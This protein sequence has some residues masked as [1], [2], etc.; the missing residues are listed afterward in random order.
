V[1][2]IG[3][4]VDA[5]IVAS[6]VQQRKLAAHGVPRVELVPM[7]VERDVFRPDAR[8][9]GLRRELL[10]ADAKVLAVG[11]GR[12][13]VEKR[14]PVVLEAVRRLRARGVPL[15][16]ALYGDGPER[17]RMEAEAADLPVRFFGFEKDRK[18]LARAI[19]SA[20][21]LL[22]ACPYETFGIGVAE[23]LAC[24]T[25]VVVPDAGGAGEH[26]ESHPDAAVA[27]AP[28]DAEAC[29]EAAVRLL[30]RSP[31]AR[32]K[33]GREAALRVASVEDHFHT[34]VDLYRSLLAR[35]D[36]RALPS[37]R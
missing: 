37:L 2:S 20:D 36:R 13:A 9:E 15:V 29:A 32:T 31:E 26:A 7:G 11:V 30:A 4:R 14:W 24:G 1:R 23:A 5:T 25:P 28:G 35:L 19:A 17:A 27:Y 3:Q 10:G 21:V 22:H 12:F 8:D 6:R 33:A 16:L 18:K 34:L